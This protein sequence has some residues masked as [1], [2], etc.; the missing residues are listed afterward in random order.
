MDTYRHIKLLNEIQEDE[1][2]QFG[3]KISKW[4]IEFQRQ[5][6]NV[7]VAAQTLSSSVADAI[8]YLMHAC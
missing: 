3:N 8:Q 2:L 5:K 7:K 1:G 4:H 6:M